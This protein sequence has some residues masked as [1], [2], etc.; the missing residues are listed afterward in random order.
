APKITESGAGGIVDKITSSFISTVN[1]TIFELFNELGIEIE[2]DLPDIKRFE[3]YVFKIDEK[4]PEIG[5]VL[6]ESLA[7]A[8]SAQG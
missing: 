1:G 4:L 6:N 7:D 8:K 5:D 2:K 3:E